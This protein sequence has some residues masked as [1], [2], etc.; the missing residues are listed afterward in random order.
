MNRD[1]P[2][3]IVLDAAGTVIH[4]VE[5]IAETYGRI[6]RKF[7]SSL[8]IAE[9]EE[10]FARLRCKHFTERSAQV[11]SEAIERRRWY[12][13]VSGIFG[14]VTQPQALFQHLWDHYSRPQSWQVYDDVPATL[15]MLDQ[16]AVPVA[17]GS[18]FDQ[19]LLAI[20]AGLPQLA[21]V[22]NVY[23]SSQIGFCKPDPRFFQAVANRLRTSGDRL[24]MIG[25][26]WEQDYLAPRRA[27]WQSVYLDRRS[28]DLPGHLRR[29]VLDRNPE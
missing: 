15:E 12:L 10:S 16:A 28:L 6:G 18:N 19:R 3:I 26:G 23:C 4:P 11:S 9:I 5:T 1:L 24:L 25:D 2:E 7:G 27:G 17:I 13:V 21:A 22:K 14:D 8:S 29:F 20:C